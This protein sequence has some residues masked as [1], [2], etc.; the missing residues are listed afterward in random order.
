MYLDI[1]D[2]KVGYSDNV[3]NFKKNFSEEKKN[4][5]V[6]LFSSFQ[7]SCEV[8]NWVQNTDKAKTAFSESSEWQKII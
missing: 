6:L 3:L 7:L 5:F 1:H 2:K 4:Q 8:K